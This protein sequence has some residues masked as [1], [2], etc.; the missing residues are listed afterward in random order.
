MESLLGDPRFDETVRDFQNNE[1]RI[2]TMLRLSAFGDTGETCTASLIGGVSV[3]A[4]TGLGTHFER[5]ETDGG[6][7][8]GFVVQTDTGVG[9][10]GKVLVSLR[11]RDPEDEQP[12]LV[13]EA[14]AIGGEFRVEH[15]RDEQDWRFQAHYLGRFP[16]MPSDSELI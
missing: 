11:P 10:D 4:M 1:R 13:R 8:H 6:L 5:F 2:E 14:E 7:A 9:V 15:G 3:L 16:W 12:E